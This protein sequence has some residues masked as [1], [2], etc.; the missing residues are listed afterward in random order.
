MHSRTLTLSACVPRNG[1]DLCHIVAKPFPKDGLNSALTLIVIAFSKY[2]LSDSSDTITETPTMSYSGLQNLVTIGRV[3][4]Q[5]VNICTK[6][7][8]S[9]SSFIHILFLYAIITNIFYFEKF[10]TGVHISMYF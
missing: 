10:H 8:D 3:T 5:V 9:V 2:P 1:A 4:T 7:V 6:R